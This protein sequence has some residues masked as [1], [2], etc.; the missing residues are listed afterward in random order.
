MPFIT[1]ADW[2]YLRAYPFSTRVKKNQVYCLQ[3]SASG[4][5]ARVNHDFR[6]LRKR[7]GGKGNAKILVTRGSR[8]ENR[9]GGGGGQEKKLLVGREKGREGRV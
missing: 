2:R 3:E 4:R 6:R 8:W 7:G 1:V 5:T 9:G